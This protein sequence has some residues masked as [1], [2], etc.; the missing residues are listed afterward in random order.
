METLD[1]DNID[2]GSGRQRWRL[3][4]VA[5]TTNQYN[6][7]IQNGRPDCGTLLSAPA[8]TAAGTAL[9]FNTVDSGSG[10]E[11]YVITAV[12][13]GMVMWSLYAV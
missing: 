6:M 10:L 7:V 11:R 8:C 2:D 12:M 5:G 13:S 1:A 9:G 4:P 3:I